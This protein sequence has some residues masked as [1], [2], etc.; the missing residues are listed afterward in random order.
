M[1]VKRSHL[2]HRGPKEREKKVKS[3]FSFF[4]SWD[5]Y[6]LCP[7]TSEFLILMPLTLGLTFETRRL[8]KF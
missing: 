6:L 1:N 7:W 8:L 2:I 4:L 3:E 5:I